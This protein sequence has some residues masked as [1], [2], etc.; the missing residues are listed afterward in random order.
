MVRLFEDADHITQENRSPETEGIEARRL[1]GEYE[2]LSGV[3]I[4]YAMLPLCA[5]SSLTLLVSEILIQ[6]LRFSTRS[7]LVCSIS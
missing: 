6:A 5:R 1:Y 7:L 2:G 3:L 4:A